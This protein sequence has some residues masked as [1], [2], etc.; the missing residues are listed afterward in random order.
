MTSF[1]P[2]EVPLQPLWKLVYDTKHIYTYYIRILAQLGPGWLLFLPHPA[3]MPGV[4]VSFGESY[5]TFVRFPRNRFLRNEAILRRAGNRSTS[6]LRGS[7]HRFSCGTFPLIYRQKTTANP[8]PQTLQ[9]PT[10]KP[11]T[12]ALPTPTKYLWCRLAL[13]ALGGFASPS[14]G[15]RTEN[16]ISAHQASCNRGLFPQPSNSRKGDAPE[17]E[18]SQAP[19]CDCVRLSG[20]SVPF[21]TWYRFGPHFTG[22]PHIS[23]S[24]L[25]KLPCTVSISWRTLSKGNHLK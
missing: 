8:R 2:P 7:L 6:A 11:S 12:T 13:P 21:H 18:S 23:L 20:R 4:G 14:G 17:R 10:H 1:S 5:V 9:I 19:S 16:S 15:T 25:T 24:I 3:E 22:V